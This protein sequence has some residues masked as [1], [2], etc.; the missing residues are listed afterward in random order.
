M[1]GGIVRNTFILRNRYFGEE[2]FSRIGIKQSMI[3]GTGVEQYK[4]SIFSKYLNILKCVNWKI[5]S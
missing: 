5:K 3:M 4:V 2:F 1:R